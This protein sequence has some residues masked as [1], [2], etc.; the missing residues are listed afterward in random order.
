MKTLP[1][2]VLEELRQ[3]STPTVSNG[4]EVFGVRGRNEGFM[5]AGVRCIFPGLGP[6]VGYAATATIRAA[7]PGERRPPPELWAHVQS[8][9]APRIVVIQ[10][11]DDPPGV[12]AFGGEVNSNIQ[13]A[14]G[15]LGTVTNG[16]VRDL[17][18][19]RALGFHLFAGS[20]GVSHAYLHIMEVGGPVTI[21]GLTVRRGDLLHGDQHGVL[22]VPIEIAAELPAAMRRLAA[23]AAG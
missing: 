4:I 2:D 11:L 22:S 12:G 10:D 20:V 8:V 14:L 15:C 19:V 16:S 21:G 13:R 3:F 9:P 1:P 23:D 18:E 5:D 6:M 7:Q 17:D